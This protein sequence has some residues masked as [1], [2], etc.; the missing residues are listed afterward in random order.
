MNGRNRH[1]K[2]R[3]SVYRRH[4][5]GIIVLISAISLVII[6]GVFLI[7]GNL[8]HKQSEKRNDEIDT[9]TSEVT[10]DLNVTEK[11]EVKSIK[12]HSVLLETT[13]TSFFSDRIDALTEKQIFAASIPL[14]TEDGSL[15][16]KSSVAEELGYPTSGVKVTLKSAVSTAE[17]RNV[18]LS[19]VFYVNAFSEK[20]ALLRSVELSRSAAIIAEALMAGI[21]D[22][23][24]I[25]PHM[26]EEHIDE[27]I[28]FV[29]DIKYLTDNGAV[30]LT[31]SNNILSLENK[32][33]VSE[34]IS[35]LDSKI[36]FLAMDLSSDKNDSTVD[37]IEN[38]INT[39]KLYLHMYKMRVLLPFYSTSDDQ[40]SVIAVVE[41]SGISNY[42]I[43]Q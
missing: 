12:G 28:R 34:I 10:E 23:V 31:V 43:I 40:N 2:Y 17:Q 30:G 14:N 11:S 27:A 20:D 8:L 3:R 19:G 13:D 16:F 6:I 22:V 21:N 24:I 32:N 38:M 37:N 25:A 29:Q 18:Y 41:N 42:Q 7:V 36:D 1:N 35:M 9:D 4:N 26:T 15:L 33:R 5:L 39:E